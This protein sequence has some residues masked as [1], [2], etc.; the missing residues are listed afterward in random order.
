MKSLSFG[1]IE[2]YILIGGGEE[3]IFIIEKLKKFKKK[4][5]VLTNKRH[6]KTNIKKNLNFKNYLKKREIA[7]YELN[8]FENKYNW[9]SFITKK[10]IGISVSSDWIFKTKD[11]KLFN[12]RLINIHNSNLP[13]MRGAGGLSWNI[14]M[15]NIKSGISVHMVDE[16]IDTGNNKAKILLFKNVFAPG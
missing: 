6:L 4:F 15:E 14:L 3:L 16:N 8:Q 10:S 12:D 1:N 9:Q 2:N 11:I 13:E 5:I 7:F